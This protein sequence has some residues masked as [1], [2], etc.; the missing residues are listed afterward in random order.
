MY[1]TTVVIVGYARVYT[2]KVEMVKRKKASPKTKRSKNG[3]AYQAH[4]D[5]IKAKASEWYV[6][7]REAKIKK[8][9]A[10]CNSSD[11]KQ[12]QR[13]NR[14][15]RSKKTKPYQKN[16]EKGKASSRIQCLENPEMGK[17]S[18]KLQ[19]SKSSEKQKAKF[20]LQYLKNSNSRNAY[21]RCR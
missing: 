5:D 7:N 11:T 13:S 20:R 19:F 6:Q 1:V 9:L 15:V 3:K 2:S 18:S 4:K 14:L 10:Y 12:K 8:S 21:F 16:P 17:A